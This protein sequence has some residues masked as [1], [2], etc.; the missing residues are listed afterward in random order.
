MDWV[1]RRTAGVQARHGA[2]QIVHALRREFDL[3]SR[4]AEPQPA[5]APTVPAATAPA[6]TLPSAPVLGNR[7]ARRAARSRAR[8]A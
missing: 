6:F 7:R 2:N 4:A 1:A 3:M 8:R 5:P